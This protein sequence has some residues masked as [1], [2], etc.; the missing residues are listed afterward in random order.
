MVKVTK[1][2]KKVNL[3]KAIEDA[4]RRKQQVFNDVK[5]KVHFN[6]HAIVNAIC[7]MIKKPT[8]R[9]M[10]GCCA[11]I[12]NTRILD[13]MAGSLQGVAIICTKDKITKA[14]GVQAKYRNLRKLPMAKSAVNTIGC[15][16]GYN[17]SLLHHKFLVGLDEN[18]KPKFVINGSFNFTK[19]A[20]NHLENCMVI[21]DES[22]AKLFKDEFMR[23]FPISRPLKL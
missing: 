7:R 16:S 13:S 1:K 12:T 8:T 21:E 22:V 20:V 23:L 6:G 9:Y 4:S 5:I 11:W 2:K 19:S 15:G 18:K 10:L 14:K 17:R 3:N